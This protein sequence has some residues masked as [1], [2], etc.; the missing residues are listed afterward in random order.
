MM[1]SILRSLVSR[2][3]YL[4]ELHF[5]GFRLAMPAHRQLFVH[6]VSYYVDVTGRTASRRT[7]FVEVGPV[8]LIHRSVFLVYLHSVSRTSLGLGN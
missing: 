7:G 2:P 5:R 8:R 6:D 4:L 1:T 3:P